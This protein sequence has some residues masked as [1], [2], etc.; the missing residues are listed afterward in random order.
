MTENE[1]IKIHRT[2]CPVAIQLMS[3]YGSKIVKAKWTSQERIS[4]LTGLKMTGVD[5]MGL[6]NRIT[7]II[8]KGYGINMRSLNFEGHEGM[9]EGIIMVYVQ[10]TNQ[11]DELV[12]NLK[13]VKGVINIVRIDRT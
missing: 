5:D 3:K 10:D 13:K 4:F 11:L 2:N 7:R 1:G 9:F 8:S 12:A 6:L